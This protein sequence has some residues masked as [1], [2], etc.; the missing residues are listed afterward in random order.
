V[1]WLRQGRLA[2]RA[3]YVID[4]GEAHATLSYRYWPSGS[5]S[6]GEDE[7]TLT[8]EP[9][10]RT[11][12]VCPTPGCGRRVRALYAPLYEARF[13]CR[14][15][16]GL[17]YRPSALPQLAAYREALLEPSLRELAAL[18]EGPLPLPPQPRRVRLP[19]E[20]AA[21]LEGERL[22]GDQEIRLWC[23]RLRLA[24]LSYRRIADL[25]DCPKSSV[26]RYCQAGRSGI[27][28]EA[29]A[30]ECERR[31]ERPPELPDDDD[32][33]AW[34][35]YGRCRQRY[36]A[37]HSLRESLRHVT[38]AELEERVLLGAEELPHK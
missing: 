13:R 18:P 28:R 33:A 36:D 27:D 20:L 29:L 23:L 1:C 11:L 4:E 34:D 25:L 32:E 24:G 2:G 17:L 7:F 9:G 38:P 12:A 30:R 31:A 21:R 3:R 8:S 6:A 10:K 37:L 16:W 22:L 5:G 35:N 15:C 26:A 14:V 19:A